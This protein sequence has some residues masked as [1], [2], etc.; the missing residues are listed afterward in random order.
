MKA[1]IVHPPGAGVS[2]EDVNINGNGP[3]I[4]ILENGICG[5]DREIVN[6]ELSAATSLNGFL[7][8]GHEALGILEEDT[9]N[10]RKGDLVMPINRRGCGRC[11]NCMLGRPD[12]CETGEQLEAG[13]S[14]MHGFM[15]EYIND[16]E[17]YL[18]KVPDVI[19][20]I[21]IMAQPLADLEKSIEEMISIQ[22]RLHWPCI[23][24]TYNCRK[25]LITG[26][27]T[28]GILFA[29]LLKTYGFSV[30]IS[31]KR[32]PNDIESKI[33]DELSVKYK[34]LSNKI[35]ES[36]D[37]II[38]ASGSGTD[39]IERTLPLLK[40]N[41]FYG[42]FGFEKT[43]TLNLTS[44]FLQGIVYKS[45]N[46]TGLINGQKPHMEMAMNHLIQWKKQFPKT[47]SMMITEKV[48]INNERRLKEVLSKKRP[49]E[50]KIKIIW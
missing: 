26:T 4:K 49:G 38:E 33:F 44:E 39:V 24:G 7:V 35:D 25:V 10:L 9:K 11:L 1:I 30:Y 21:A 29:M 8:L 23:D 27:G 19:R 28:I 5:T 17:R 20:D 18:V 3:G 14:G 2:I 15:R 13:I 22:K 42:I 34:N 46:I 32:E 16:D 31:N 48:S 40:N 45:I 6:G 37:A 43:G 36:F 41:G 47:T 50:I 12:F